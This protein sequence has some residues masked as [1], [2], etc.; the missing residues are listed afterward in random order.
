MIDPNQLFISASGVPIIP[1][2]VMANWLDPDT[3]D[4]RKL[5]FTGNNGCQNSADCRNKQNIGDCTNDRQC[6]GPDASN[7]GNCYNI[8]NCTSQGPLEP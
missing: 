5:D 6:G 3:M 8:G 2:S 1:S 7:T 4:R